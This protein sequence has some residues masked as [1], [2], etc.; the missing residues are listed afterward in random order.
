MEKD[1]IDLLL[2]DR[3]GGC[4]RCGHTDGYVNIQAAHWFVCDKHRTKWC[5]GENLFSDWREETEDER[6]R[7]AALLAQYRSVD[8]VHSPLNG[9][10]PEC[11]NAM[12]QFAKANENG[13]LHRH[14]A[15]FGVKAVVTVS[16][17]IVTKAK[18]N[19]DDSQH[20][21]GDQACR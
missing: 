10:C 18:V 15:V 3:F 4:P 5:A 13:I 21:S 20:Y 12:S 2:V 7:S 11:T 6:G 16:G 9:I 1:A 14:C 17:G 19:R 8:P